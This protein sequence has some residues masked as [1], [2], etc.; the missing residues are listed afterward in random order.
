MHNTRGHV[1]SGEG[2][3]GLLEGASER[4]LVVSLPE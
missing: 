2:A 1:R 4:R 3:V